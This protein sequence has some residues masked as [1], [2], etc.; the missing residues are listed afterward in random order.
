MTDQAECAIGFRPDQ[1]QGFRI[2][3]TSDR[4]SGDLIDAFVRRGAQVLHAPTIRMANASSDEPVIADTRAII[5]ARPD[6]LLATTAY[7]VRRWFEVADAAGL[8]DD[9]LDALHETAILVRGPK[10]RGG[11]RAAGLDDV[12]MSA[13]ETTE[14]L[15]DEVLANHPRGLTVAVQLH[16]YLP[17]EA[18]DRLRDAHDTVLTVEPYRWIDPDFTDE[19]VDRLIEA[20]CTGGL[21]CITFTSAPAVHALLG[22]AEARGRHDDL[23]DAMRGP[24]VAAAVGPVTA[25]PLLTAGIDALQP[26]RFRMG[27]MIRQ[28]CEHLE[29]ERIVRLQTQLGPL[30][31]RGSAV[32]LGGRR[33]E[34]A[35]LGLAILRTLVQARGTVVS[36]DRLAASMPGTTDEHALEVALS[37]LRQTLGVPGLIATVVKRGYRIDV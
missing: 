3:V 19:R 34:L 31:L 35:P 22:A 23:I 21:D 14:S 36:R 24:V 8:G 7:G 30:A 5:E 33:V 29:T 9:L 10:A 28:V 11:I 20:A 25:A 13:E 1:L 26:D 2:G 6:V 12:G 37:R 18:L 32:D 16:G 4:R 15:I 17:P 27:A